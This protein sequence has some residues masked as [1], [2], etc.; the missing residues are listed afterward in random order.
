MAGTTWLLERQPHLSTLLLYVA[1]PASRVA[2]HI[3][4][5]SV[6]LRITAASGAGHDDEILTIPLDCAIRVKEPPSTPPP[7][8]PSSSPSVV[9]SPT[10][11]SSDST[12][13][14]LSVH[15][16]PSACLLKLPLQ[17]SHPT[18][19]DS[20]DST[21]PTAAELRPTNYRSLVCRRCGSGLLAT[22][23]S[24]CLPLPSTF[25]SEMV[26]LWYCHTTGNAQLD[27]LS[28]SNV[29][30][31][32]GRLLVG[33]EDVRVSMEDVKQGSVEVAEDWKEER[34]ER[35]RGHSCHQHRHEEKVAPTAPCEE[36]RR[37][38]KED[39]TALLPS[40][41]HRRARC[42]QCHHELGTAVSFSLPSTPTPSPSSS[43]SPPPPPSELH[44]LKHRIDNLH[45]SATEDDLAAQLRS[46][47]VSSSPSRVPSL[48]LPFYSLETHLAAHLLALCHA[49]CTFRFILHTATHATPT[50]SPA[51]SAIHLTLLNLDTS[52]RSDNHPSSS[53]S[54][55]VTDARMRPVLKVAYEVVEGSAGGE[56]EGQGKGRKKKFVGEKVELS[57]TDWKGL[58]QLLDASSSLLPAEFRQMGSTQRLAFIRQLSDVP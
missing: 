10:S 18:S 58:V 15:K 35:M 32:K 24:S 22:P 26:D 17:P 42:A 49:R 37:E 14:T 48:F 5:R 51:I 23:P 34:R 21:F 41:I 7:T 30:V 55:P 6:T 31:G 8:S 46:L 25:W 40:T 36:H 1:A 45:H 2:F 13:V 3:T 57:E 28:A 47:S 9:P 54:P 50:S 39:V 56:G 38:E 4:E 44:L 52:I 19:S 43:P 29:A 12:P 20:S 11:P 27:R 53:S 16:A 33:V